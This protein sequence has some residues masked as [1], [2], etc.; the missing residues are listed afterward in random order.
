M[1]PVHFAE[2]SFARCGKSAA[3]TTLLMLVMTTICAVAASAQTIYC[4]SEDGRRTQCR[5]DTR[6]GVRLIEQKSEAACI[7]GRTWGFKRDYIWV[8]R[9]CRADFEVGNY[10][11]DRDRNRDRD[12]DRYSHGSV[13][14]V[15]KVD[16]DIKLVVYG[17]QLDF[18]VLSGKDRG[19]GR[20][21]FSGAMPRNAIIR[22]ERIRGRNDITIT[23]Q[24]SSYNKYS[25]AVRI[26]DSRGGG[27]DTEVIISW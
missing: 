17:G 1:R 11:G 15:G 25:A 7:E 24:P 6:D 3:L 22:V 21:S 19:R 20:Y 9:G 2:S 10:R 23:E 26:T 8:D 5:V 27:E 16:H 13:R 12:R 18:Y 4:A 14:W